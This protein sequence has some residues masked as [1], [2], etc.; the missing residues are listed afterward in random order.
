MTKQEL[1]LFL[2]KLG[3]DVPDGERAELLAKAH[4]IE[5]MA[6]AV[7]RPLLDLTEPLALV[8]FTEDV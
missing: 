1:D 2:A 8:S 5:A 6:A 7:K 4:L 3:L